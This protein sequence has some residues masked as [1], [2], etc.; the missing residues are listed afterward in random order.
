MYHH[1][2]QVMCLYHH[3]LPQQQ[4]Q[5]L[6]QQQH[7]LQQQQQSYHLQQQQAAYQQQNQAQ[8]QQDDSYMD[9][10]TSELINQPPVQL[11]HGSPIRQQ[12]QM[13]AFMPSPRFAQL[14]S[15]DNHLNVDPN[16]TERFTSMD[17]MNFQPPASTFT[18][19]G[20]GSSTNLSEI[21]SGQNS[22]LSNH[23]VNNLPTALTSDTSPPVQQHPQFQPQQ[24]QQQQQQVQQYNYH[25]GPSLI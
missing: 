25:D 13:S 24:Q 1:L 19:L 21:S 4:Q 10:D 6:Q 3:Q 20:N 12:P 16:N 5:Q 22:L 8:L 7:Q 15:F 2:N 14:E 23:S 17:S 11:D 18:Q 9:E